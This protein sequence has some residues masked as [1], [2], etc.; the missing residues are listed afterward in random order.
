MDVPL[1]EIS[2]SVV[3]SVLGHTTLYHYTVY[4]LFVNTMLLTL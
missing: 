4:V 1:Y 3:S 2:D